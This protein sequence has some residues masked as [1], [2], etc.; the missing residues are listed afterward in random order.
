MVRSAGGWGR[1][2]ITKRHRATYSFAI[3]YLIFTIL[4]EVRLSDWSLTG[5]QPGWCYLTNGLTA[6]AASHP[7]TDKIYV[8]VTAAGLL[9]L[10]IGTL[11]APTSY[12]KPLMLLCASQF[13]IHLYMMIALRVANQNAL[14]ED[15]SENDWDFGQTTAILLLMVTVFELFNKFLEYRHFEQQLKR[16]P[17][18]MPS[19]LQHGESS[20]DGFSLLSSLAKKG[21]KISSA[22][23]GKFSHTDSHQQGKNGYHNPQDNGIDLGVVQM[24]TNRTVSSA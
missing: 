19:L 6:P 8:A 5:D 15:E 22:S 16:D 7:T 24:E 4:L 13:P 18:S 2:K 3:F 11:F 17:S 20:Y 12:R 23:G 9:I 1:R 10:I 21:M 14:G